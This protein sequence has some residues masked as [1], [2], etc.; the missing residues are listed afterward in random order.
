VGGGIIKYL[1]FLSKIIFFIIFINMAWENI[2]FGFGGSALAVIGLFLLG[3]ASIKQSV[4]DLEMT[5]LKLIESSETH[6]ELI[7]EIDEKIKELK[8]FSFKLKN[9]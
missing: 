3:K 8:E 5:K 4:K 1:S 6:E 9:N 7:K 2:V